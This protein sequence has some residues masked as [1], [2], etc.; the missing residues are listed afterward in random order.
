MTSDNTKSVDLAAIRARLTRARGRDYWRSLEQL[1]ETPGFQ[2]FLDRE[3]PR[4]ASEWPE[5]DV[6]GRR[7]FMKLAGASL[8]L[9]GL[10]ACTKQPVEEIVP[11][12]RMPEEFVPGKP[13]YFATAIPAPG[14]AAG[15][16]AESHMGRPTKIEGNPAHPA[17][18]GAASA[19]MQASVLSLYDPD[20]SQAIAFRGDIR[21]YAAFLGSLKEALAAQKSKQGA[22]ICFLT[23]T[24]TSPTAAAQLRGILKQYPAAK[25]FQFDPT[26]A[27]TVKAGAVMAF[28]EPVDTYYRLEGAKVILSLGAD[29]LGS[30]AASVRY[31]REFAAGRRVRGAK[32]EMNRLYAVETMPAITGAKAD[33][34]LPLRASEMEEFTRAL[35]QKADSPHA[36]WIA[37]VVKDLEQHRGSSAVIPGPEQPAVVHALAHA[38]NYRLGNT[39]K[40][41]IHIDP[42][43][44]QHAGTLEA[45]AAELDAGKVE[46]LIVMGANPVYSAPADLKFKDKLLQAPLRIHHGP[47]NDETGEL[48]H[49]H[50]PDTHYL[51][52][53]SDTRAFDGTVSI[54]QPLIAPLYRSKSIHEFLAAFTELPERS[55]YDIVRE[56][57]GAGKP[58]FE[59]WWR[60]SVHDGV[61]AGTASPEKHVALKTNLPAP[62]PATAGIEIVFRPDPTIHDGRFSNLGW[63]QE[64]PKPLTKITWD[65]AA[66][67]SPSL[68]EKL[69]LQNEELVDLVYQ[70]RTVKAPVWI[71]PGHAKDSVTVHLGY[72]RTRAGKVG[73]GNGFSAY[74]LRTA[75]APW[76][77]AGLEIRKTGARYPL[78]CTQDHQSMEGRSLA[79]AGTVE[80]YRENPDF[81]EEL[82]EAPPKG[83]T[84]YP[85]HKYE[86]Y[87]WGMAIDLT[88]CTGCNACTVACQAENN[89]PVVGKDQ[90]LAGR[91]M[92]WIRVDR[93][94]DGDLDNPSAIHQPVPC[95]HC[96]NAPCE[97]VCPVAATSHSSEGLNDMTYNRC[98][99][100]KYCSNNCPYKVRRFNF[101]LYSDFVNPT[102]AMQ[103][104]PDVSVRSRGVMEK[105][106]YCVQ[107]INYARIEAKKEDRAIRDGEAVTACEASCPAQAIVFGNINDPA[108]RVSRL[109]AEKLNYGML[110]ELNTKPRTTYLAALRNPNPEMEA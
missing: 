94:F 90:V 110:A 105:C 55:G 32:A 68:A 95:M 3:F 44:P 27:Q 96:E 88:S 106:S 69:H 66:M 79:L 61:V 85:D 107:R 89:I 62:A 38:I 101:F 17:S 71:V 12:V 21:S 72:G 83:L 57:W 11:Y 109:K 92:H 18:L 56:Q 28:G 20:R 100:T 34:R 8:A 74:S 1:A 30:G 7:K 31:A 70:N 104:N 91:E 40:T 65:N 54:I 77:G 49:W 78:A 84:L 37:A 16:L 58:D 35:V 73:N 67:V 48:C 86:G 42:I 97:V 22:G 98:V 51:E 2:E 102:V 99:G 10:S 29:F 13:L 15:V 19:I 93:Y 36:K 26:D 64:L 53:W 87:A 33:H 43:E 25:W 46:L 39:G 6:A 45:L 41:V 63:L 59:T 9:A 47:Y 82:A 4:Q 50:I 24:I 52:N 81:L 23:E 80:E 75:D 60:K 103:K 108:S 5:E 14:G 76:F